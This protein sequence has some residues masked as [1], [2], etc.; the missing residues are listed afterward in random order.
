MRKR[1]CRAR[2]LYLGGSNIK[3]T[4]AAGALNGL[5]EPQKRLAGSSPS[6]A[7]SV[8]LEISKSSKRVTPVYLDSLLHAQ[9]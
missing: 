1:V 9:S 6:F 7:N 8:V 4:A 3:L 2:W 5:F